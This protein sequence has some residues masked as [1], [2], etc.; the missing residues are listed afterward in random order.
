MAG[1]FF[2]IDFISFLL[3]LIDTKEQIL[4]LCDWQENLQKDFAER[5]R[6]NDKSRR[7]LKILF[8]RAQTNE[9]ESPLDEQTVIAL[10]YL[11]GFKSTM[12]HQFRHYHIS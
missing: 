11:M 8:S 1:K 4:A 5:S 10:V 2:C 12:E 3:S 7:S 6:G 9:P